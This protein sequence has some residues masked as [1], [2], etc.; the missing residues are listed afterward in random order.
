MF[1]GAGWSSVSWRKADSIK[2]GLNGLFLVA[3]QA[4]FRPNRYIVRVDREAEVWNLPQ[5][6]RQF[7]HGEV[8]QR[9]GQYRSMRY[10]GVVGCQGTECRSLTHTDR[11]VGEEV[12][13]EAKGVK[14][15][16]QVS[17]AGTFEYGHMRNRTES[18][19]DIDCHQDAW[20]SKGVGS[21]RGRRCR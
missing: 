20:I 6:R 21:G 12:R 10:P 9:W 17:S 5:L 3:H 13:D 15:G 1:S 8:K 19:S 7:S 2:A 18:C 4:T 14:E 16:S 11:P